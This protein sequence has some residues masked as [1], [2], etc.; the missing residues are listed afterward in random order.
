MVLSGSEVAYAPQ[1]HRPTGLLFLISASADRQLLRAQDSQQKPEKA[2]GIAP[3]ATASKYRTHAEHDGLSLG[4]ELLTNKQAIAALAA[5][6]NLCRLVVQLAVFPKK[7]EARNLSLGDFMLVEMATGKPLHA[8]NASVIVSE[9]DKRKFEGGTSARDIGTVGYDSVTYTN[10]AGQNEHHVYA[11]TGA[12]VSAS[13][14]T[15]PEVEREREMMERELAQKAL[16]EGKVS[17]PVA[18]YLYFPIPKP[19]KNAKYRLVY[20]GTSVPIDLDFP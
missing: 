17:A 12:D 4:A 5:D 20:S 10:G 13:S 11:S 14:G 8:E 15:P 1:I 3:R 16:P 18:G 9:I 19:V 7:D 2:A 6:V